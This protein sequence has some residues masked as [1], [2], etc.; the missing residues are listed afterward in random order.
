MF[1][2]VDLLCE[3]M[4]NRGVSRDANDAMGTILTGLESLDSVLP[5]DAALFHTT[6][7]RARVITVMSVYPN[8][9]SLDLSGKP[10]GSTD[11]LS[12]Q[13][14]SESILARISQKQAFR[15][16]LFNK[17]SISRASRK[18]AR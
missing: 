12:P 16:I 7:R 13:A 2:I 3:S 8:Q 6:P 9:P 14:C 18:K 15:F 5:A 10:M 17:L 4:M 1:T 11:I